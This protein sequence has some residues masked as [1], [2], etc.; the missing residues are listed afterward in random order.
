MEKILTVLFM[1]ILNM[2][3]TAGYCILAVFLLRLLFR[4]APRKYLYVLW[5]AVAFRLICPVSVSTEF[6]LFNL[7]AF[8][9]Q[10]QVT[11]GGAMEYLPVY[12]KDAGRFQKEPA[13]SGLKSGFGPKTFAAEDLTAGEDVPLPA[14]AVLD[15]DGTA[16]IV[17]AE[18]S[19]AGTDR[20]PYTDI[21]YPDLYAWLLGT[22]KYIW[23]LGMFLFLLY[24]S[25]NVR[26]VRRMVRMAVLAEHGP[27]GAGGKRG[28]AQV[29]EC[30][31]LSSPFVMGIRRPR[32]YLPCGLPG[33]QRELVLLHERY[34]IRRKDH[35]V[36]LFSFGLLAVYWFH[37]LVWAAWRGM[38]RDME[39]SCD[40]KVL[41]QLD[42]ERRKA[43]GMT[44]LSFAEGGQKAGWMSPA[45]GEYDVKQRIRH[46]L[47]FKKPAVWA[48]ALAVLL[49]VLGLAMLGTNGRAPDEDGAARTGAG[50]MEER[51]YEA[52]NPYV[53]DAP[54]DGRLI[55][56]IAEALPDSMAADAAFTTR[57]QTSKEPYEFH[58]MLKEETELREDLSGVYAPSV[59]MLALIENL[60]EVRWYGAAEADED[61][62]LLASLNVQEAEELCKAEDL[63][64]YSASPE[65]IKELLGLLD[66][67][68][69]EK[70]AAEGNNAETPAPE[71]EEP[72]IS[73]DPEEPLISADPEEFMDWY[74]RIPHECYEKAVPVEEFSGD[75]RDA[76]DPDYEGAPIMTVLA[77]TEDGTATLYGYCSRRRYG[78]RGM[79]LDY[80]ATPDGE[81]HPAYLN[82]GQ[83][84]PAVY[85]AA[86]LYKA[87]YDGDGRDEIALSVL[88]SL[89]TGR[90]E[91]LLVLETDDA[92]QLSASEYTWERYREDIQ[93]LVSTSDDPENRMIHVVENGS[94]S[95]APLLSI[96][97]EEN[98]KIYGLHMDFF[99]HFETG[100]E[101]ILESK[102]DLDVKNVPWGWHGYMADWYTLRFRVGYEE[103]PNPGGGTFS[104]SVQREEGR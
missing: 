93:K 45:F 31:E 66:Q 59:L 75:G 17:G 41:E 25:G 39:M 104:L 14:A 50:T 102:I 89:G 58:F 49:T 46:V 95:S 54:A 91:R 2:S 64:G 69:W 8:S 97:Y 15:A 20:P 53:G 40:E 73:T 42:G 28:A 94:A 78:I 18:V 98:E 3:E 57:L 74:R 71:T 55:G 76:Y 79:T 99:V 68:E 62:E 60:G 38:C 65:R 92:G 16:N 43:Y 96:P 36:K 35:L 61:R 47:V 48:G 101:I 34:H 13:A 5:L 26:R 44:L 70:P 9:G 11:K 84:W 87:D 52:G 6:S 83:A 21:R 23:L 4:K 19:S 7:G 88:D 56:V 67:T 24:F 100:E 29:Y 22:G 32:I 86:G 27:D 103:P 30:D 33:G 81:S 10:A 90:L 77:Q 12:R 80:R 72:L 1:K 63:K 82:F 37:P 51:L 85:P